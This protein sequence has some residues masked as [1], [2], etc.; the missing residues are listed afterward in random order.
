[1]PIVESGP[2]NFAGTEAMA[3]IIH[4]TDEMK[5]L[6]VRVGMDQERG[7]WNAPSDCNGDFVYVPVPEQPDAFFH[8]DLQQNYGEVVQ[9]LDRFCTDHGCDLRRDL[10]FPETLEQHAMH[11][12]PDF[13][14]LTYGNRGNEKGN[15]FRN[16]IEDDLLVFY[17]GFRQLP[18]VDGTL[19]YALVGLFVI[20]E[21]ISADDVPRERWHENAHTRRSNRCTN[22]VIV[23]AK[24]GVS[25]RCDHCIPIGSLHHKAGGGRKRAYRVREDL[26]E[27]WGGLSVRN[28]WIQRNGTPP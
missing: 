6:L 2:F 12:D 20:Q 25:G 5:A 1:M 13:V 22:D 3:K 17:T 9:S 26:L 21:V 15:R 23:R 27:A 19:N 8:Q 10:H 14:H 11:L 7:G 28:G 24:A 4:G 16:L 18:E